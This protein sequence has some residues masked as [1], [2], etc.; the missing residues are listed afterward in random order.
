MAVSGGAGQKIVHEQKV[1]L[2][3][4]IARKESADAEKA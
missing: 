4:R 2:A 1:M 3:I